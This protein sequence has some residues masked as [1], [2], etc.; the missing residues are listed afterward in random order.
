MF[1]IS[2]LV[3]YSTDASWVWWFFMTQIKLLENRR[4]ILFL[5]S[6]PPV[7]T[8]GV[9]DQKNLK[10]SQ[11][12]TAY[13]P[14]ISGSRASGHALFPLD[15]FQPLVANQQSSWG[16]NASS[17]QCLKKGGCCFVLQCRDLL[18]RPEARFDRVNIRSRR[19]SEGRPGM[20][21][22]HLTKPICNCSTVY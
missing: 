11:A 16:M 17:L 18:H 8:F 12:V 19:E 1:R 7:T 22:Y 2:T 3:T 13:S 21:M 20:G 9:R 5:Y 4:F 10:N 6:S 15:C 14:Q